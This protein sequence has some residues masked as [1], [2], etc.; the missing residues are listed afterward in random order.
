[1][2]GARIKRTTLANWIMLLSEKFLSSVYDVLLEELQKLDIVNADETTV[3][4]LHEEGRKASQTSYMWVLTSGECYTEKR[5][6]LFYY[7][8]TRSGDVIANLLENYEGTYLQSDGYSGYNKLAEDIKRVACLT[9]ARRKYNDVI[10]SGADENGKV[11]SIAMKG[12]EMCDELF[13]LDKQAANATL[14]QATEIKE[15]DSKDKI[16]AFIQWAEK[17]I[18]ECPKKTLLYDA[19]N[20]TVN[21]QEYIRNYLLDP[22]LRLSNNVAERT[23]R[24]FAVGRK[25]WLFSNTARGADASAKAYSIIE[26]AK[27]NHLDPYK[28]LLEIF[29]QSRGKETLD[30]SDAKKLLPWTENMQEKCKI[31]K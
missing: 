3:Q 30:K 23:V 6:S 29:E 17:N 31:A 1:M 25:I 8:P 16:D 10:K 18:D 11:Y 13:Q 14:E 7:A 26:T 19:L 20:Y 2:Q 22:R 5:I 9:H 24:P 27:A 4:V 28:Y 15:N 21:Q 12:I